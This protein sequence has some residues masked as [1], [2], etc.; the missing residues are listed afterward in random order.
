MSIF[1]FLSSSGRGGRELNT[2]RVIPYLQNRGMKITVVVLDGDGYVTDW[3][4]GNG[5]DCMSLGLWP[6]KLNLA[7]VFLRFFLILRRSKPELV[8]VYGFVAGMICRFAARP[9]GI[10]VVVGIVGTENFHGIRPFLE[11]LTSRLV[12]HYVTNFSEG[13][14][15]MLELLPNYR[16]GVTVIQNGI[17]EFNMQTTRKQKDC[18]V[19]GTVG[20]LKPEK[21]YDVML[22]ALVRLKADLGEKVFFKYLIAGEGGLRKRLTELIRSLD[23]A[24]Q[25]YL[26]GMV[27]EVEEVLC[28]IDLFVLPSYTE[29][30]PN[31]LLEAMAAGR[32]VIA[33]GVG[34]VPEIIE[35]GYSGLV[36]RPG[37]PDE[38]ARAMLQVILNPRW[39]E[40]MAE[41]GRE[42]V[43][44]KFS[45]ERQAEEAINVWTMVCRQNIKEV[46]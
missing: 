3:C 40:S 24:E 23:L 45:F 44:K 14:Q 32:C 15:R 5:V 46:S 7:A 17:P 19:V 4:A 21:G 39:R 29:G 20:N 18:F 13:K 37:D 42:E 31:A 35:D 12:H 43:K 25:V 2:T 34:G 27:E 9:L 16:P 1:I 28:E 6:S 22:Q 38:L 8:E 26:L 41:R 10:K 11:R 33:T 36:V 30:L